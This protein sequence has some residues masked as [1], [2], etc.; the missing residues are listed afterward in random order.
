MAII[1][2]WEP[3]GVTYR[4]TQVRDSLIYHGEEAVLLQ[5]YRGDDRV[6][7]C[8]RCSTDAYGD[9]EQ[10]CPVCYGTNFYDD[11]ARVGGVK[12]ANRA[13]CVFTDHTVSEQYGQYGTLRPDQR[14]MQCEAFPLLTEHDFVVRVK[15]WNP[16]THTVLEVGGIYQ[17]DAVTRE[18]LRTGSRYGQTRDDIVGQSAQVSW[19]P[20]S[21]MG[22]ELYPVENVTFPPAM[23]EGT[24]FPQ[25]V[26]QPDTKVVFYPVNTDAG[27]VTGATATW[28]AAYTF[29]QTAPSTTWTI[30]HT[31]GHFPNF[32]CYVDGE[33]VD[34]DPSFP[35]YPLPS[36]MVLTFAQPQTGY[37]ELS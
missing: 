34:A 9:G 3:W 10:M 29:P 36:P 14:M 18:S 13:W 5:M 20:P 1:K 31:L 15:R 16:L 37:V 35:N 17:I 27:G 8:P 2:M 28:E 21:T 22:I 12:S 4:R 7:R 23:I 30:T 19:V 26:V 11:K 6:S 25:A 32:T 33:E 24:P